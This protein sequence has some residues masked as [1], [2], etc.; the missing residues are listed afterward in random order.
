MSS[1]V[2]PGSITTPLLSLHWRI[3][4]SG[5]RRELFSRWSEVWRDVVGDWSFSTLLM[6]IGS[7]ESESVIKS[8]G[9]NT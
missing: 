5:D 9:N 4:T 2:S 3:S 7:S 6:I 8:V 1:T